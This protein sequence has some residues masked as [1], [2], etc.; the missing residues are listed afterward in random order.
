MQQT[1]YLDYAATTPIDGAVA[2]AMLP[3]ITSNYGNAASNTHGFGIYAKQCVEN[4]RQQVAELVNADAREIIFTS[5]ATESNNLAIK[6]SALALRKKGNHIITLKTEHKSILDTCKYLEDI[7]FEI[8]Y[9]DVNNNGL[10]DI[11]LLKNAIKPET[12]LV[13][14]MHVNNEIGVIQNINEIGHLCQKNKIIFHVDAAQSAGKIPIDLNELP[15]NLMSFSGHKV[16]GPQGIGA[17]YI[18]RKPRQRLTPI[19]H[20]GGHENGFRSGTLAVHQIIGMGAAFKL[21]QQRLNDDYSRIQK[22]QTQL[23]KGLSTIEQSFINGDYEQR[24][25]HNLNISFKGVDGEALMMGLTNL[26]V[27][28][29]SACT[30]ASVQASHVLLALGLCVQLASASLRISIGRY[31]TAQQIECAIQDIKNEV[32]RLRKMSPLW[33]TNKPVNHNNT[34]SLIKAG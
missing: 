17:L 30:S 29:G 21:A 23:Y 24:V 34:D 26:A 32:A 33:I 1:I 2:D 31:T 4:A 19:I 20:G 28:S 18:S 3:W 25:A 13:S 5:G 12:I 6:G 8:T 15:V 7:G 14:V 27:S 9:L 11:E 16:Y 10:L 22:L